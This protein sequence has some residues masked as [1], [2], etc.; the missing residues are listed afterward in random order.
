MRMRKRK[1]VDPYLENE[2]HYIIR[3]KHCKGQWIKEFDKQSLYLEIGMGMGD[4]ITGSAQKNPDVLYLG[5]EKDETCVAKASRKAEELGV[6]NFR[7]ILDNA[8]NLNEYFDKEVDRIYLHFSDPWPKKAHAKRRLTFHTYLDK[9]ASIL[10]DD[11][12]IVFKTDNKDLF[13][14][15]IVEF[16]QYHWDLLEFS[17]DY[18]R[19]PND[20]VLTAY[21]EKFVNLGQPIY[22]ARIAK[23]K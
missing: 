9:Y 19:H 3:D 4:F 11:G 14:F 12:D 20:D 22:Y 10:K 8:D 18:H 6:D 1:W 23:Q 17:V 7:V 15:S 5:F 21:E 2:N 13:E 16:Q